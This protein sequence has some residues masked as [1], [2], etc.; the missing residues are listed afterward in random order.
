M[1]PHDPPSSALSEPLADQPVL[2]PSADTV[3]A[4]DAVALHMVVTLGCGAC[5]IRRT[6]DLRAMNP[7]FA[8]RPLVEL[9]VERRFVCAR[10]GAPSDGLRVSW[11]PGTPLDTRVVLDIR[12]S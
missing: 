1:T 12:Q 4:E 9:F 6:P 10:C 11:P 2:L 7:M 8:G 5:R 3:T